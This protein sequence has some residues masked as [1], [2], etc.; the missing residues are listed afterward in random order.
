MSEKL[1]SNFT[2]YFF[3]PDVPS[4]YFSA[5]CLPSIKYPLLFNKQTLS[6]L[7]NLECPVQELCYTASFALRGDY[8][9]EVWPVRQ[10]QN[11]HVKQLKSLLLKRFNSA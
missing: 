4:A 3:L 5:S 9:T 2:H 10:K 7:Q 8:A 1:L 11:Y 6:L